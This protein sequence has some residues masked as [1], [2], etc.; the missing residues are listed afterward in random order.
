VAIT[1][2]M[3]L[4]VAP[5]VLILKA[6]VFS[7]LAQQGFWGYEA[8]GWQDVFG[9]ERLAAVTNFCHDFNDPARDDP[10]LTDVVWSIFG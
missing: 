7:H 1:I 10:L 8:A 3:R 5:P 2:L 6:S 9:L 4:G